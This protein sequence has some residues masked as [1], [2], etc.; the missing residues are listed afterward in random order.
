MKFDL[1]ES[2]IMEYLQLIEHFLDEVESVNSKM[3]ENLSDVLK[4]TEYE[5]L[6]KNI[7]DILARYN[8]YL[9]DLQNGI[10]EK[11]CG[12][13]HSLLSVMKQ[14]Y[15]GEKGEE[16]CIN[17]QKKIGSMVSE[18][19]K[20]VDILYTQP[21]RP[22]VSVEDFDNIRQFLKTY[23]NQAELCYSNVCNMINKYTQDNEIYFGVTYLSWLIYDHMIRFGQ[24]AERNI[25]NVKNML[26]KELKSVETNK[27]VPIN[28]SNEIFDIPM[29]EEHTNSVKKKANTVN[30]NYGK[31]KNNVDQIG[32]KTSRVVCK[33]I[34]GILS[35]DDDSVGKFRKI[36]EVIYDVVIDARINKSKGVSDK[37][38]KECMPIY[39]KL[40]KTFG[41]YLRYI[42]NSS[43]IDAFRQY[44][45]DYNLRDYFVDN[46]LNVYA[47]S[48][49]NTYNFYGYY[50]VIDA[51]TNVL[52]AYAK[53]EDTYMQ[54]YRISTI[55]FYPVINGQVE[56][57]KENQYKKYCANAIKEI[58]EL[59]GIDAKSYAGEKEDFN[60]E[61]Q[62]GLKK[63]IDQQD[64]II[65]ILEKGLENL[66]ISEINNFV[67]DNYEDIKK[68]FQPS[69]QKKYK[70]VGS[71]QKNT[72]S[73]YGRYC[74]DQNVINSILYEYRQ[75]AIWIKE[76]KLLYE[77]KNRQ[78]EKF[79]TG[80]H[81]VSE[82]LST[83]GEGKVDINEL[84]EKKSDQILETVLGKKSVSAAII[85]DI[86]LGGHVVLNLTKVGVDVGAMV[87]KGIEELLPVIQVSKRLRNVTHR[88]WNMVGDYGRLNYIQK[89]IDDF[90]YEKYLIK[91]KVMG[92]EES[93]YRFWIEASNN[94]G[95]ELNREMF[96][97][98]IFAAQ[99]KMDNI[100]TKM[101][102]INYD[103]AYDLKDISADY[104]LYCN[105][106]RAAVGTEEI[107]KYIDA[108]T[109]NNIV[110][111]LYRLYDHYGHIK[112]NTQ[113]KPLVL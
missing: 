32:E 41:R 10:Y 35:K 56:K 106:V 26:E 38:I 28:E 50:A 51:M 84:L 54:L 23:T 103:N 63:I 80:I 102:I 11:W 30:S 87:T 92:L 24:N 59:F 60:A 72:K 43:D 49:M 86:K 108:E 57:A 82:I 53:G 67:D 31:R 94:Q 110:D 29:F 105:W 20:F 88:F 91:D 73:N 6:Q 65:V 3:V 109:A 83:V 48:A 25:I 112:P 90:L 4:R 61:V 66:G 69:K 47:S 100:K 9:S 76:R 85:N 39:N 19:L 99:W 74:I 96:E 81:F 70:N 13:E 44:I 62:A 89:M 58:S 37:V 33:E 17:V 97:S 55:A 34:K 95:S 98:A 111:V 46:G 77:K 45:I 107:E 8:E 22:R 1:R 2:A 12:S 16:T 104:G 14:Y 40:Y 64:K 93:R 68:H 42:G 78:M 27:D 113:L 7:A 75:V 79:Q 15:I 36:T 52:E 18:H 5:Y 71:K 21:E 101:N